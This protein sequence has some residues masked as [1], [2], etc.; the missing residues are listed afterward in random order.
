MKYKFFSMLI[1]GFSICACKKEQ[2]RSQLNAYFNFKVDGASVSIADGIGINANVFDCTIKGDTALYINVDKQTQG[3]GFV[4]KAHPLKDTTYNLDSLQIGYYTDPLDYR[5]YYT[6]NQKKG[7][8]TIKRGTF[9]AVDLL[10]TLEGQFSYTTVDTATN[11]IH[12]ITEGKFLM[13]RK[14]Q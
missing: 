9:Q 4:I 11:A 12:T 7:T 13:E 1:I 14:E 6:N 8:L 3:A 10:N 2:N 5:R